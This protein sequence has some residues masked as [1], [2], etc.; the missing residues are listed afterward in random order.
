MQLDG[1]RCCSN[2]RRSGNVQ[3]LAS[4][5]KLGAKRLGMSSCLLSCGEVT[6]VCVLEKGVELTLKDPKGLRHVKGIGRS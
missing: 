6:A 5:M 1:T 2:T 3:W 4:Q